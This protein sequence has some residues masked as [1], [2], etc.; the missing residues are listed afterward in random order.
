MKLTGTIC[1]L[2][3]TGRVYLPPG[4]RKVLGLQVGDPL[5][6]FLDK[7]RGTLCIKRYCNETITEFEMLIDTLRDEGE[8]MMATT[9]ESLLAA[10]KKNHVEV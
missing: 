2:E 7:E 6:I 8:D 10:Y 3:E 9:M 5:D 1:F 4:Y